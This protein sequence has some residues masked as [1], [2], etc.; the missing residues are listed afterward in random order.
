MARHGWTVT[1]DQYYWIVNYVGPVCLKVAAPLQT[2]S[3]IQIEWV[4]CPCPTGEGMSLRSIHIEW[5]IVCY[6]KLKKGDCV[7]LICLKELFVW[8]GVE[9]LG[10]LSNPL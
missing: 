9:F 10:S 3:K 6:Q 5:V 8:L 1:H 4:I 2:V 7:G